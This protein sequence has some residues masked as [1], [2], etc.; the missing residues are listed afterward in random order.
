MPRVDEQPTSAPALIDNVDK[1]MIEQLIDD[2]KLT[3]RELARRT[4]ISESAVSVRLRRLIN[5]GVLVFSAIID[6]EMA[7]FEWLVICRIKTRIRSPRE[8]AEDVSAF[9]QCEAVAVALGTYDVLGYFLVADRAELRDLTDRVAAV[10][11]LAEFDIDLA[12]DTYVPGHGRQLMMTHNAPPIRLPAPKLDLDGLDIAII[13][14]LVD[15]GRQSSRTLARQ[16]Q[17][18]EGT[19]RTR[20]ARLT[21]SGLIRVLALIEPVALGLIRVVASVSIRADRS[22]LRATFKELAESPNV[23]F[24]ASCLGSWGLHATVT[25]KTAHELMATVSAMQSIDGIIATDTTLIV[26]VVRVGSSMKRLV[27]YP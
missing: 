8:V 17:V 12:T 4:G 18:S 23:A 25:A 26:E 16:F 15:N 24:A 22:R 20:V 5:T 2:G 11:G 27:P 13:H 9:P 7:G 21:Q 19:V 1:M 10:D 14:A 6:W 3:N